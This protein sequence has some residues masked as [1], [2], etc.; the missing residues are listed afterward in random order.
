M[1]HARRVCSRQE[2]HPDLPTLAFIVSSEPTTTTNIIL[3]FQIMTLKRDSGK[4]KRTIILMATIVF[5]SMWFLYISFLFVRSPSLSSIFSVAKTCI[6]H[7]ISKS[8]G[9][10]KCSPSN[11]LVSHSQ[12]WAP[13]N[14][15]CR[16][17]PWINRLLYQLI[18]LP[19][20]TQRDTLI[21]K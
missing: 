10:S 8:T 15:H 3:L 1:V 14:I 16:Q 2:G 21:G 18:D 7:S 17:V 20:H 12:E 13:T 4:L 9:A 5:S 6:D 19:L 11:N